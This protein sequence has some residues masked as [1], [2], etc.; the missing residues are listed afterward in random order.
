VVGQNGKV[1]FGRGLA[2]LNL[3]NVILYVL[4]GTWTS[5][6][7]TGTAR[8]VFPKKLVLLHI[9]LPYQTHIVCVLSYSRETRG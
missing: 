3:K 5:S 9:L 1:W 6:L 4:I 2:I 8:F 7:V